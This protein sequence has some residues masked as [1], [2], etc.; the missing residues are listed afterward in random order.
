MAATK[1]IELSVNIVGNIKEKFEAIAASFEKQIVVITN[2]TDQLGKVATTATT[3]ANAMTA[4][5]DGL[6]A[7]VVPKALTELKL[8]EFKVPDLDKFI[9]SL[10]KL[11]NVTVDTAKVQEIATS[12]K[13]LS[14]L[15]APS[16]SAF[17][18]QI[19]KLKTAGGAELS[20]NIAALKKQL[21]DLSK[22]DATKIEGISKRLLKLQESTVP[23]TGKSLESIV[24]AL[25]KFSA[26]NLP[27]M[28]DFS[29][30]LERIGKL[31]VTGAAT[32]INGI[33]EA[34]AKM[35]GAQLPKIEQLVAGFTA[36]INLD[37]NKVVQRI[38]ELAKGIATLEKSGTL[39]VFATFA[40]D[41]SQLHAKL[42]SVITPLHEVAKAQAEVGKQAT[43][44]ST[45]MG[46][47]AGRLL[48]YGQYRVV[49]TAVRAIQDAFVGVGTVIKD[50]DQ[51]LKDLQAVTSATTAEVGVMSE[52]M[53]SVA[54]TTKFSASEVG[55][56][57][58]VLGQ[59]GFSASESIDTIQAVSDLATGTLA[60]MAMTVDLVST[61][62]RVFDIAAASSGHVADVFATAVNE[63]KLDIEKLT[64]A[65][66]YVGP[67]AQDAGVSFEETSAALMTLANSGMRA[68][69][70]GTSLRNMFSLLVDPS[71]KLKAA[72]ERVG[73]SIE[74]LNPS[75]NSLSTV[76]AN[77]G[78]VVRGAGDAFDLFGKRG[79]SAVLTLID[80]GN[81]FDKMLAAVGESGTAAAMAA[82]QMEGLGVMYKN[83]QDRVGLLAISLGNAGVTDVLKVLVIAA[84]EAAAALS[85]FINSAV[86]GA[87]T[88]LAIFGASLASLLVIGNTV[89][90]GLSALNAAMAA[91]V[92]AAEASALATMG[93]SRRLLALMNP[94]ILIPRLFTGAA[95]A[96]GSFTMFMIQAD[97]AAVTLSG[98]LTAVLLPLVA[99]AGAL[100]FAIA[101]LDDFAKSS[102]A[103][104]EKAIK[105][106]SLSAGIAEYEKRVSGLAAGSLELKD[107]NLALRKQLIDTA[108][109]N[110]DVADT[111]LAAANSI[112]LFSGNIDKGATAL[113]RYK[114]QV[115]SLKMESL[116]Q[117]HRDAVQSMA[118]QV[119]VLSRVWAGFFSRMHA[120]MSALKIV[121]TVVLDYDKGKIAELTAE[122]NAYGNESASSSAFMEAMD[123]NLKTTSELA[124]KF[125]E[126]NAIGF[127]KLSEEGKILYNTLKQNKEAATAI[128]ANL[129][130][131]GQITLDTPAKDV[132]RIVQG[133]TNSATAAKEVIY[134]LNKMREGTPAT[135]D[136]GTMLVEEFKNGKGAIVDFLPTYEKLGGTFKKGEQ[137]R[138]LAIQAERKATSEKYAEAEALHK[139]NLALGADE[140][141]AAALYQTAKR[142]ID[143][144]ATIN[145]K[146]ALDDHKTAVV[147][148]IKLAEEEAEK[149]IEA[150]RKKYSG[151]ENIARLSTA[152]QANLEK[153]LAREKAARDS[154]VTKVA[155]TFGDFGNKAQQIAEIKEVYAA[156]MQVLKDAAA[157]ELELAKDNKEGQAQLGKELADIQ[158]NLDKKVAEAQLDAMSPAQLKEQY[159]TR[160]AAARVA[161]AEELQSIALLEANGTLIK[162]EADAQRFASTLKFNDRELAAAKALQEEL[163]KV[164][165]GA[166]DKEKED[167]SQ[168]VLKMYAARTEFVNKEL[169]KQVEAETK[170]SEAIDKL[171]ENALKKAE[172]DLVTRRE[173]DQKY[174]DDKAAAWKTLQD[175]L[176]DISHKAALR[177]EEDRKKA[178]EATQ[179]LASDKASTTASG[180]DKIRAIR[181]RTMSDKEKEVS[182]SR[183]ASNKLA[184]GIE[185]VEQARKDG[186]LAALARGKDL[187]KQAGDIGGALADQEKAI[188]YVART[189]EELNKA[190][191]TEEYL[192]N[193][194]K[195]E[196]AQKKLA[197]EAK[198]RSDA[199]RQ[200]FD[201]L[202]KMDDAFKRVM[203]AEK[204][205]HKLAD[206]NLDAEIKKW[207]RKLEIAQQLQATIAATATAG[208]A[209]AN[210]AQ[211][212]SG[213]ATYTNAQGQ[214]VTSQ[215][216]TQNTPNIAGPVVQQSAEAVQAIRKVGDTWTNVADGMTAKAE[217][218]GK[219]LATPVATATAGYE[220]F[221]VA[222]NAAGQQ[223][224]TT[225]ATMSTG[226]STIGEIVKTEAL[227]PINQLGE[228]AAK[229][230][231]N[232]VDLK[233]ESN[234]QEMVSDLK[235]LQSQ[236]SKLG[237]EKKGTVVFSEAE[238]QIGKEIVAEAS[239]L[240]DV[241]DTSSAQQQ[242][243]DMMTIYNTMVKNGT[244]S[245]GE[246][247]KSFDMIKEKA[248]AIG[249][250]VELKFLRDANLESKQYMVLLDE[251]G[252]QV[253]NLSKTIQSNPFELGF[254]ASAIFQNLS[255]IPGAMDVVR[256]NAAQGITL[257]MNADEVTTEI[258]ESKAALDVFQTDAA[259][260]TTLQIG[261]DDSA[262]ADA[263]EQMSAM[264]QNMEEEPVVVDVTTTEASNGVAEVHEELRKLEEEAATPMELGV[265]DSE[266]MFAGAS[267]QMAGFRQDVEGNPLKLSA[268][269]EALSSDLRSVVDDTLGTSIKVAFKPEG[270]PEFN[271]DFTE[272]VNDDHNINCKLLVNGK[273]ATEVI[274]GLK[275]SLSELSEEEPT[276][277]VIV[278]REL[279]DKLLEDIADSEGKDLEVKVEVDGAKDVEK[280]N[281]WLIGINSKDVAVNAATDGEEEVQ[282]LVD[283]IAKVLSKAVNITATVIGMSTLQK[284]IDMLASLHN[285]T[286]VI[287]TKYVT[288]GSPSGYAEGGS[289][290]NKLPSP[291]IT[292]GG[293][294]KDDVPAMLMKGEFVLKQSAV[295]KYGVDFLRALNQGVLGIG[296]SIQPKMYEAGGYVSNMATGLSDAGLMAVRGAQLRSNPKI[297]LTH[298]G[299]TYH[300]NAPSFHQHVEDQVNSQKTVRGKTRAL[301]L[302]NSFNK[303][304]PRMSTGGSAE[305]LAQFDQ[306]KR[307]TTSMY[308][309]D[310]NFARE[311]GND[312][313]VFIL[314]MEKL[315]LEQLATTLAATL[316]QIKIDYE[317]DMLSA[318]ADLEDKVADFQEEKD[319]AANDYAEAMADLAKERADIDRAYLKE[320]A[321]LDNSLKKEEA[322]YKYLT[323]TFRT[324]KTWDNSSHNVRP[325]YETQTRGSKAEIST[326][327][328][329][330]A[331]AKTNLAVLENS[332]KGDTAVE[333]QK[334]D[335]EESKVAN[336][337]NKATRGVARVQ[338]QFARQ[339]E[340]YDSKFTIQTINET[341]SSKSEGDMIS[342]QAQFD[343]QKNSR[344]TIHQVNKLELELQLELIKLRQRYEE[345]IRS[346]ESESSASTTTL[347]KPAGQALGIKYWLNSGGPVGYP[348]GKKRKV[349]NVL[350]MLTPGE[351]VLNEEAVQ[352]YG[353]DFIDALNNREVDPDYGAF[354]S[355][356]DAPK[357]VSMPSTIN[358]VTYHV[359]APS[360]HNK[361][362]DRTSNLLS[363][364]GNAHALSM[365]KT[366]SEAVPHLAVGGDIGD[367]QAQLTFE[368]DN[369]TEEYNQKI[370][371]AKETGQTDLA[372][373]LENEKIE[374]AMIAEE[375][376]YT[377]Q[378][379]QDERDWAIMEAEQTLESDLLQDKIDYEEK[380]MDIAQSKLDAQFDMQDK[381]ADA[382]E[383]IATANAEF[384]TEQD[385][386]QASLRNPG[387][388]KPYTGKVV[389]ALQEWWGGAMPSSKINGGYAMDLSTESGWSRLQSQISSY[390]P[391]KPSFVSSAYGSSYVTRN[392]A[393]VAASNA[394]NAST[395]RSLSNALSDFKIQYYEAA[396]KE[397]GVTVTAPNPAKTRSVLATKAAAKAL[398]MQQYAA[399]TGLYQKQEALAGT[400]YTNSDVHATH[401]KDNAIIKATRTF[402]TGTY[403]AQHTA[404]NDTAKLRL[405]T[406]KEYADR[407]ADMINEVKLLEVELAKALFDLKKSYGSK[408]S[409]DSGVKYWL[410][411][412]GSVGYP[413][414]AR[415]GV[416]SIRAM[417]TPGEYVIKESAVRK[418][419]SGFFDK[420]N[421]MQFPQLQFNAGGL[422][423]SPAIAA[424]TG[425]F[426]GMG[427]SDTLLG[428]VNLAV[429]DKVIPVKADMK[430]AQTLLKEFKKMGMRIA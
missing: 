424:S 49:S 180:E 404:E 426:M 73:V 36:L 285:K 24:A 103:A 250:G 225:A 145:N 43:V 37:I 88:K 300:I 118:D 153:D 20:T 169:V 77:L 408:N 249:N 264:R 360:F 14:E 96:I 422:V 396:E 415:R 78:T 52:K 1:N 296:H 181:Q 58:L 289:V 131:T 312:Q 146:K 310:I 76:I 87:V 262:F 179:K 112:D 105:F 283:A 120:S 266:E 345:L 428:T 229:V 93:L 366:F 355:F 215:A 311:S 416:D 33:A 317:A 239:K 222:T 32:G 172:K 151:I 42:N 298:G 370:K 23:G 41:L 419:G 94:M 143:T 238:V 259:I 233:V 425:G 97:I 160:V 334:E 224:I 53:L 371:Y 287:T 342:A 63:S 8:P 19:E 357:T 68:S 128:I 124:D 197:E 339:K 104:S 178:L 260:P 274:G 427:G 256:Q 230:S 231:S 69:T 236:Y 65:F 171:N 268:D 54:E 376:V 349:D 67:I 417:L 3:A 232:P 130:T 206:K 388:G 406:A 62:M 354:P 86:G 284:L 235:E 346:Q 322:N 117:A 144:E 420:I 182:N 119:G 196:E 174:A 64:T 374:L 211:Q 139:S 316:G 303:I 185:L 271:A 198:A 133:L 13:S 362:A 31:N 71:D 315:Q 358:G 158:I 273:D 263:A 5:K 186:D 142:A 412:G 17:I 51:S 407:E 155:N 240:F 227:T 111:A 377:L 209:P 309:E 295:R 21:G 99:V 252:K 282:T 221:I 154:A 92:V 47:F 156:K 207:E 301:N 226:F 258:A 292:K 398:L 383:A 163:N 188:G 272:L 390:E 337:N 85:F 304:V 82:I 223:V 402:D 44:A 305:L 80:S 123:K 79:A 149:A 279:F 40:N 387:L 308:N 166:T 72:A 306:E 246:L 276:I 277:T 361:L 210:T 183:A 265:A 199:N 372:Y 365:V 22:I 159:Q 278:A 129:M 38:A 299:V 137:E 234:T 242:V 45:R 135:K 190:R 217:P 321:A 338:G 405:D 335:A 30:G 324:F 399:L 302:M 6:A 245:S 132:E 110:S 397:K 343:V 90:I 391:S 430:L 189:T 66:N 203:D 27:L 243:R 109:S 332:Y 247:A 413:S 165:S 167:A 48:E 161:N 386:Y 429:G 410:N 313:E 108:L 46:G 193:L 411:S 219:A 50:Y 121:M 205:M 39:K 12:L 347:S 34:L 170:A 333:D 138:L 257:E 208:T 363:D 351:Y 288:Q 187:I 194:K 367:A 100:A 291:Y 9:A 294:T 113:T 162:E 28:S 381:I 10:D 60:D 253:V 314:E 26:V 191:D 368:L 261:V 216:S 331:E 237:T 330:V 89:R 7:I 16:F 401:V 395:Q 409:G 369:T 59:A 106:D 389:T 336:V 122:M 2:I 373:I 423:D 214:Q 327:A 148:K 213:S 84:K 61:A 319:D 140:L 356:L 403:K 328:V 126:L 325:V 125:T 340:V 385:A 127:T 91:N 348:K 56:G 344:D 394:S 136:V 414:A 341:A 176:S 267:A 297:P 350:A 392:N 251:T 307:I 15:K 255:L 115:N 81:G 25:G 184:E 384:K 320:K 11:K 382:E 192:N 200:Y 280:L 380:M 329:K 4:F 364:E 204:E 107:A 220:K 101:S 114:E 57:M 70:I 353:A 102:Q 379:L 134:L 74:Q 218:T 323:G 35:N 375:L 177:E 241:I 359:N 18:G 400:T 98:T 150:A 248:A 202:Q 293:G 421:N 290:F 147:Q 152:I 275:A 228:A 254:D 141:T 195:E 95:A 55:K 212:P 352:H 418:L 269:T 175:K 75:T 157:Q 164:G 270:F 116:A 201:T 286:V 83:L 393:N 378:S 281:E 168:Q 173:A 326:A 29:K 244:A 318:T